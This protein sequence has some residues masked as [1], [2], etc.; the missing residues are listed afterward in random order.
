MNVTKIKNWEIF[1]F[2]T[3][4]YIIKLAETEKEYKNLSQ[5]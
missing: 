1:M 4:N 2:E 5:L 3:E